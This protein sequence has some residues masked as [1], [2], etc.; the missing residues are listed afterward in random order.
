MSVLRDLRGIADSRRVSAVI[1]PDLGTAARPA[2]LLSAAEVGAMVTASRY[3]T[4][5]DVLRDDETVLHRRGSPT[6]PCT[7][8]GAAKTARRRQALEEARDRIRELLELYGNGTG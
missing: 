6:R 5:A 1:A 4:L 3:A 2:T 7:S 8:H